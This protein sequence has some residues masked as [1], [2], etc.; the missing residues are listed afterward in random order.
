M[1][2]VGVVLAGGAGAVQRRERRATERL[3]DGTIGKMTREEIEA[4]FDELE[5]YEHI[6]FMPNGPEQPAMPD[7]DDPPPFDR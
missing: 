1:N 4:V 2:G 7:D 6:P 3:S 5:T